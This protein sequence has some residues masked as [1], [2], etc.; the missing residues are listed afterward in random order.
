MRLFGADINIG[1]KEVVATFNIQNIIRYGANS[2][3]ESSR[4]NDPAHTEVRVREAMAFK[5]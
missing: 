3:G 5:K 1:E 2:V 4:G